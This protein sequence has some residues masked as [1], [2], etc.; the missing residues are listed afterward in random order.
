[1]MNGPKSEIVFAG[2]LEEKNDLRTWGR[3]A[4]LDMSR[5][6]NVYALI[7]IVDAIKKKLKSQN[8]SSVLFVSSSKRRSL[9]TCEEIQ[10][11]LRVEMGGDL[12]SKISIDTRLDTNDQGKFILPESYE[13][14]DHFPGLSAASKIYIDEF[15]KKKNINYRFGDP[16]IETNGTYLY[17]ELCGRFSEYGETY[18]EVFTR[19][20]T[21]VI[22]MSHKVEKLNGPTEL[23]VVAHG[24]TYH[25]LRGL[26][27][28]SQ[29]V[30]KDGLPL[31]KGE[32]PFKVWDIYM[33]RTSEL[34]DT[35]YGPLDISDLGNK[36]LIKILEEE[37]SYLRHGHEI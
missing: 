5:Q 17:P 7:K 28:L 12:K 6:D 27:V 18:A 3:D 25:I 34:K 21:S 16:V 10:S 31:K 32:I 14:G 15:S 29:Q 13:A 35:A 33:S 4:P 2:H 20:L 1:M 8:K 19:I 11:L 37:I 26:T 9:E 36:N 24:L 23:V 30:L 22:D